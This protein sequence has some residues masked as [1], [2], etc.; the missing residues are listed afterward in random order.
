MVLIEE[1]DYFFHGKFKSQTNIQ[2]LQSRN[3]KSLLVRF[4]LNLFQELSLNF[5]GKQERE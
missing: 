4:L 3:V 5:S 1:V 2:E